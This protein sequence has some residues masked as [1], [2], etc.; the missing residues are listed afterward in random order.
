MP[1]AKALP[2]LEAEAPEPCCPPL[3]ERP[4]TA[5]EAEKTALM[6]KALDDPVRLRLFGSSPPW[7]PRWGKC[8]D[9]S[10]EDVTG[11]TPARPLKFASRS[12]GLTEHR[13]AS[14]FCTR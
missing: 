1:D 13:R 5:E 3:N 9:P 8:S 4:L 7:S 12:P 14:M 6:F 10:A 2:L 11:R